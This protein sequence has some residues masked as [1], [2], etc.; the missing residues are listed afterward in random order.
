MARLSKILA[1]AFSRYTVFAIGLCILM[2]AGWHFWLSPTKIALINFTEN[3]YTQITEA[4]NNQFI[5]INRLSPEKAAEKNLNSFAAV[6]YMKRG[7]KPTPD[8]IENIRKTLGKK[9]P[10]LVFSSAGQGSDITNLNKNQAHDLT[11]YIKNG[12][13]ANLRAFLNYNRRI[14]DKKKLFCKPFFKPFELPVDVFFHI[15][16]DAFF[17][18]YKDYQAYYESRGLFSKG[19]PRVC[20]A[21]YGWGLNSSNRGYI[22]NLIQLL[23]E[24]NINVYPIAGRKKR[25]E[26]IKQIKPDLIIT[27]SLGRLG[28]NDTAGAI[29][30][31]KNLNAPLLHPVDIHRPYEQWKKDQR[32]IRGGLLSQQIVIPEMD[33]AIEPFSI[34]AQFAN[35]EGHYRLEEIPGRLKALVARVERWLILRQKQNSEKRVAVIYFK[36][37]GQ[38]AMRAAGLDVVPSLLNLLRHLKKSGF[39]TGP[40]PETADELAK[41]IQRRGPVLGRYAKGAF[42]DFLVNGNPEFIPAKTYISWCKKMLSPVMYESV[43]KLYGPAPGKYLAIS[44]EGTSYIA[45]PRLEFGNIVLIPQLPPA[46]GDDR[47][48]LVHGVKKSPPHPY[49]ATYLWARA[50]FKADALIHFGTHGS[51]EFTPWRQTALFSDDWPD[52]LIGDLPHLYLYVINNIGEA[53]IAKRRSYATIDSHLTPP[54]TESGLYGQ[55]TG[56]LPAVHG[57]MHSENPA[58]K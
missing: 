42:N 50:G 29:S 6:Y 18:T 30:L 2:G 54:F 13:L 15:K 12:G 34:S 53:V 24:H 21:V 38:N 45:L 1:G 32:G 57:Y 17:E 43:E 40:L 8:E 7:G 5:Q 26:F 58:L 25:L 36:G 48:K 4:N 33:G 44:H 49:I 52:A 23:E 11:A 9:T 31:L 39:N 19:R 47:F 3:R 51:L 20:L 22:N 41:Q 56:L 35:K 10:F 14:L 55:F 27:T 37:P 28:R 46:L 16:E